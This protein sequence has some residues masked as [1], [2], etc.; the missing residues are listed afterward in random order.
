MIKYHYS[1]EVHLLQYLCSLPAEQLLP[2]AGAGPAVEA[3]VMLQLV[4]ETQLSP[5]GAG[6]GE[7]GRRRGGGGWAAG[8]VW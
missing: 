1:D 7:E 3:E 2:A 8:P 4:A 5:A 6:R